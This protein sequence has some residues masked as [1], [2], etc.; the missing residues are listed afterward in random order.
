MMEALLITSESIGMSFTNI[1]VFIVS[2]GCLIFCAKDV[3][4]GFMMGF[5]INMLLGMWF[6]A[7][8]L[9]NPTISY[10]NAFTTSFIFLVFMALSLFLVDKAVNTG[11]A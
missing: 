5:I 7:W 9:V 4:L 6:Y 8:S 3:K 1:L 11:V 2:V 10:S